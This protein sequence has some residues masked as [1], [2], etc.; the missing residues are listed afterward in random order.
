MSSS[1]GSER[2]LTFGEAIKEALAE[3]LRRDERVFVM[4]EEVAEY[5]G[6]YKVT[7]GL[8]EEFGPK[9]VI[10]TP[11]TEYG[12]AGIIFILVLFF[13]LLV[14]LA[15]MAFQVKSTF[16]SIVLIG[17]VTI[18]LFH[19]FINIGMTIG[20]APV[21]GL[22]LPFLSYGGSFLVSTFLMM[23]VALNLLN[24]RFLV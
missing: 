24:N 11:I 7:Q 2:I 15:R 17:I 1:N 8:L 4:G 10:D 13:I 12:F 14:Y 23:G 3:E 20:L 19:I 21:T 5:Q 9:R 16:S 22:P 6:A 18:L